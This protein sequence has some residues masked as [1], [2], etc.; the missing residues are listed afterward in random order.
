M[1]KHQLNFIN[2]PACDI[3]KY[4]P[5]VLAFLPDINKKIEASKKHIENLLGIS[6]DD[7]E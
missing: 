4:R 2:V 6:V 3:K 5:M 1:V 7:M